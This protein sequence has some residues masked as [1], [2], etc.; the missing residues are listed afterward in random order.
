M[1]MTMRRKANYDGADDDEEEDGGGKSSQVGAFMEAPVG[2]W[3]SESLSGQYCGLLL[4][5]NR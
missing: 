1:M 4:S 5:I 2:Y 3:G